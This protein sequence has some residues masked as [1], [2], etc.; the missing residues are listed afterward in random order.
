MSKFT[1]NDLDKFW[2]TPAAIKFCPFKSNWIGISEYG[3]K[4]VEVEPITVPETKSNNGFNSKI[5]IFLVLEG[6]L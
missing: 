2:F 3:V 5:N 4:L 6:I 1:R